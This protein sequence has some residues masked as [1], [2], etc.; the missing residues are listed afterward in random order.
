VTFVVGLM[1]RAGLVLCSDSQEGDGISKRNVNKLEL[2]E[3]AGKWGVAW[4]CSGDSDLISKF[5]KHM[6]VVLANEPDDSDLLRLQELTESVALK[7]KADYEK[8]HLA[9]V[10][11]IWQEQKDLSIRLYSMDIR[12]NNCLAAKDDY[13]C[14]G[15]DTSLALF[16]LQNLH[17][18]TLTVGAGIGLAIFTTKLV[19]DTAENVGGPTQ[20][21]A[22][23]LAKSCWRT[24][25]QKYINSIENK[26]NT[27]EIADLLRR[28][29]GNK[30]PSWVPPL[31]PKR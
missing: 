14:V 26:Y 28:Y 18:S 9:F 13:A 29:W 1:C 15:M 30:N 16:V 19:K 20:V 12:V 24:H 6:F 5:T 11:G 8:G 7:F 22:Y 3:R 21:L 10:C 31:V 27:D 4:G 2:S 17:N 25:E 23:R